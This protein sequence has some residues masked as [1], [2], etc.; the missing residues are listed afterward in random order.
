MPR[1]QVGLGFLKDAATVEHEFGPKVAGLA[2]V[3]F[4]KAPLYEFHFPNTC[5]RAGPTFQLAAP[6]FKS[7]PCFR[8]QPLV[9][10]NSF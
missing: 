8:N 3:Q 4:L 10:G 1:M 5:L 7:V 9:I 2:V 6:K